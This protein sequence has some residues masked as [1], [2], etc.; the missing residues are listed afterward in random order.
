MDTKKR[1]DLFKFILGI[2]SNVLGFLFIEAFSKKKKISLNNGHS[3][4]SFFPSSVAELLKGPSWLCAGAHALLIL[5]SHVVK[6]EWMDILRPYPPD[7]QS[8]MN[9]ISTEEGE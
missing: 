6:G 8:L 1:C 4:S 9:I 7:A 2:N 3:L 5:F